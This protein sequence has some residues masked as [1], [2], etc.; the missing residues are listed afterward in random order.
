MGIQS[1]MP[2]HL[3]EHILFVSTLLILVG[4]G[5]KVAMVPFHQWAPDAYEG[6][7]TPITAF[8]S[9]GSKAAGFAVILR[10]LST[11][12]S[13]HIINWTPMMMGISGLTMTIGNLTAI[14]QVNIKR[15]LAYSSIGQAGYLLIGVAAIRYSPL[16]VQ[17]TLL[18]LF[19]YL[20]MNLGA[21]AVVTMVSARINSDDIR[22]YAGLIKRAPFA[23]ASMFFFL[24]SLAGIPPTAGFLAKFYMFYAAILPQDGR[25]LT[26]VIVAI[27][28]AVISVYY[29][30]NVV[31][32]MFFVKPKDETPLT[33]FP[34]MNIVIALMLAATL[35]IFLFP[36]T[37]IELARSSARMLSAM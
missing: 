30:M 4:F 13:P 21:F 28:N 16:A 11:V 17:A 23:A 22:D 36:E 29:Y 7:P 27:A 32:L 25:L 18:Y 15:M 24:L 6:A 1:R 33:P 10:V 34:A 5:F 8:L 9:V 3:P 19:I 20:F 12:L 14:P 26:L 35:I 2:D 31:R 37:F